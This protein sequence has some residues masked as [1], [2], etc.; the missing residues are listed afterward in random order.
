MSR[1]V[2]NNINSCYDL[3]RLILQGSP[4]IPPAKSSH[5]P[6]KRQGGVVSMNKLNRLSSLITM[7]AII[8]MCTVFVQIDRNRPSGKGTKKSRPNEATQSEEQV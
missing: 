8:L 6:R 5:P 1:Y 2:L 3:K 7:I 4:P